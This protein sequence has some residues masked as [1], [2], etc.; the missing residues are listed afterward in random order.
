MKK[1]ILTLCLC[2]VVQVSMACPKQ[3]FVI[4]HGE[5]RHNLVNEF[6]S[7]P[8]HQ[9]YQVSNL[10]E[11]GKAQVKQ[12]A[13]KLLEAGLNNENIVAVYVS[14]MPRTQQTAKVLSESGLF[15]WDKV[16]LD[17]RVTEVNAGD[18]EGKR[19]TDFPD[20]D[21]WDLGR[22]IDYHGEPE[23]ALRARTRDLIEEIKWKYPNGNVLVI[24]H[25][26]PARELTRIITGETPKLDTAGIQHLVVS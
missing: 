6:N 1:G 10:T 12:S 17:N 21:H 19:A 16:Q 26:N 24:T 9:N 23:V 14:P 8:N 3:V 2:L 5:S 7:Q 11:R 4:R 13:Q 20:E 22:A 15:Q 25:G 18:R